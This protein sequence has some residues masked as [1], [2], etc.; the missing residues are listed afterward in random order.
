VLEAI[1]PVSEA[2]DAAATSPLKAV[3]VG[4]G[5]Q[6]SLMWVLDHK[7]LGGLLPDHAGQL[8][9]Q[10]LP[11]VFDAIFDRSSCAGKD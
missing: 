6:C 10:P 5:R 9:R 8:S 4:L 3:E 11:T 2:V 1:H 7:R